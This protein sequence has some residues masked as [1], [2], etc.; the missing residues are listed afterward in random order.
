LGT[1]ETL[2]LTSIGV[3]LTLEDI[4]EKVDFIEE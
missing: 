4:R 2:T 1:N 3:T